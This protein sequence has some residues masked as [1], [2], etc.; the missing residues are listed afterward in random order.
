MGMIAPPD[1][2]TNAEAAIK[3][4]T[5]IAQVVD[6]DAPNGHIV[7]RL[8]T[9][10]EEFKVQLPFHGLSINGFRSSWI[11]YMPQARDF[12][13]V[14]FGPDNSPEVV[15]YAAMGDGDFDTGAAPRQNA[16]AIIRTIAEAEPN[17]FG[18]IFKQLAPGEWDMRSS[19][20]A[21]VLGTQ[22]GT[23]TLA[24]G[25]GA[26]IRLVKGRQ[27]AHHDG[28][29][30]VG[31]FDGVLTR[32]GR[33]KRT[34]NPLSP[35]EA[36]PVVPNVGAF[37]APP[38]MLSTLRE[39]TVTVGFEPAP[40]VKLTYTDAASG[41]L[42]DKFGLP[43]PAVPTVLAAGVQ[44]T[45]SLAGVL[46][47]R[48]RFYGIDGLL[49]QVTVEVDA[50]GGIQ[51]EQATT[52]PGGLTL[53]TSKLFLHGRATA[54][55]ASSLPAAGVF[56]GSELAHEAFVLGTRW[57]AADIIHEAARTLQHGALATAHT[58]LATGFGALAAALTAIAGMVPPVTDPHLLVLLPALATLA[59][60]GVLGHGNSAT[61]EA[62]LV[63]AGSI[64]EA[65]GAPTHFLSLKVLGE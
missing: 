27:E 47:H 18:L 64:Y 20:G 48:S 53:T 58:G 14:A 35:T 44:V 19:G 16:Y 57:A 21:Y 40:G 62:A 63:T 42:T 60:A 59:G 22:D 6:V 61:A 30:Q 2:G 15:G 7:I 41:T 43:I 32:S 28:G 33:V 39:H 54:C 9:T 24:G 36:E 46:R 29:L 25:G 11:R 5:H 1:R 13:K 8:Q 49:P 45:P 26:G 17:G 51:L 38:G 31:A 3:S 50:L 23:L 56:L 10:N 4:R 52:A 12:V 65:A 34:L 55:L 37:P